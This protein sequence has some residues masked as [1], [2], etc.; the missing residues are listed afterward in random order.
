MGNDAN[1]VQKNLNSVEGQIRALEKKIRDGDAHIADLERTAKKRRRN[2]TPD[3]MKHAA[4]L[5]QLRNQVEQK[6]SAD[7][8]A[9]WK[10]ELE[11]GR[12]KS[13]LHNLRRR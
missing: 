3:D 2:G 5:D 12:L 13:V 6:V 10:L 8:N 11:R 4:S 7:A 1:A 9:L